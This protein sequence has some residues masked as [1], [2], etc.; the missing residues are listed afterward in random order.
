MASW[1][2][3]QTVRPDLADA[4]RALLYQFGVGLGFLGT[5]RPDGGPRVHPMCPIITDDGLYGLIVES[6]KARD[7]R[8]EGRY[9][10]HSFPFPDNEDACYLTGRAVE[11]TER[12][13]RDAIEDQ[14]VAERSQFPIPKEHLAGQLLVEF[15]IQTVMVTRTTGH[16]DPNPQHTIW[17]EPE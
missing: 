4:S 16:G 10:L 14:F 7:L 12:E 3:F 8:R 13:L 11:R 5:V 6:P 15:D 17:H 9:A 2:A 1:R